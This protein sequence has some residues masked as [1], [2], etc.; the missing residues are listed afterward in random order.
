MT[1]NFKTAMLINIPI[2]FLC[3]AFVAALGGCHG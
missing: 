2:F 3:T 1:F